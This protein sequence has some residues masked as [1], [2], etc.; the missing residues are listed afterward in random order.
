MNI[1]TFKEILALNIEEAEA[2]EIMLFDYW[3]FESKHN[4]ALIKYLGNVQALISYMF[5]A[6]IERTENDIAL[7]NE[8]AEEFEESYVEI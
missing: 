4:D 8:L 3:V 7:L 6:C 5:G 2:Y 1:L